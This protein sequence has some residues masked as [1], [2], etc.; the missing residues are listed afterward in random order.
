MNAEYRNAC[1]SKIAMQKYSTDDVSPDML[2][3]VSCFCKRKI[4]TS[5]KLE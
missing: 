2:P 1:L 4:L 5:Y 3:K